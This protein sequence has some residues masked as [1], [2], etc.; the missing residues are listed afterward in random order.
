MGVDRGNSTLVARPVLL[1]L[2]GAFTL[3]G[4]LV[5]GQVLLQEVRVG[6]KH[7]ISNK[8]PDDT[9]AAGPRTPPPQQQRAEGSEQLYEGVWGHHEEAWRP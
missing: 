5:K 1:R 8:F 9:T 7:L 2:G 3:P 4:D 6:P